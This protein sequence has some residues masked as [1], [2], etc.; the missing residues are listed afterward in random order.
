M[1]GFKKSIPIIRFIF[2]LIC[3]DYIVH[4]RRMLMEVLNVVIEI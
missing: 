2:F 4:S 1:N 3:A